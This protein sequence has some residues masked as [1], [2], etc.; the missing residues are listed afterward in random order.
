MV[1]QPARASH[2]ELRK[3]SQTGVTLYWGHPCR[4]EEDI[5]DRSDSVQ[6]PAMQ[7]WGRYHRPKWLGAGATHAE[8]R[9][10]SQT[11]VTRCRGQPCRTEEDITDRSDSVLLKNVGQTKRSRCTSP[12]RPNTSSRTSCQ[13]LTSTLLPSRLPP[14]PDLHN[15]NYKYN[16]KVGWLQ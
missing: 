15:T 3:I 8:L 5:T 7:N 10:I 2:A 4:T 1:P 16:D 11:G 9:K 12:C 14:P 6:G 13:M